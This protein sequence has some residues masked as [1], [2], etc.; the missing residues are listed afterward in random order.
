MII[1]TAEDAVYKDIS[2]DRRVEIDLD[3]SFNIGLIKEII[4]DEEDKVFYVLA[5][6]YN[7]KLGFFLIRM[8][9]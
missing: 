6:R 3:E 8:D 7:E 2:P 1:G 9:D 5:N 4:H